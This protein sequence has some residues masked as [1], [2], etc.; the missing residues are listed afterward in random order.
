MQNILI[1]SSL[2]LFIF[3]TEK[4]KHLFTF[5]Q[6]CDTQLGYTNYKNDVENFKQAVKQI[7]RLEIDFVVICGDLVQNATDSSY[8]EF[9]KIKAGLNIPCYVAAGNHDV[10][11]VP[12][13]TSLNFYRDN[14]G[15]DYYSFDNK[16]YSFIVT[17]SQ[18]W[19]AEVTKESEK[20]NKWFIETLKRQNMKNF[21]L[22]VIGHYPFFIDSLNEEK[23]SK[24]FPFDKRHEL[25]T[26][27]HEHNVLAYLSGHIHKFRNNKYKNIQLVSGRS[28]SKNFDESQLGFR[29]WDVS[30]DTVTHSFVPLQRNELYE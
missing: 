5:I 13:S 6:I 24:N 28:T 21:P 3:C 9:N 15:D 22:F 8:S 16:G 29:L 25:L 4:E 14:V 20:H 19:L 18:L 11:K 23:S 10:G 17:N 2:I 30:Q 7:N 26:L 27:F 12:D 1:V